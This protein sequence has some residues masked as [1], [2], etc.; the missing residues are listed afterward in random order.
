MT[1]PNPN[2]PL[3]DDIDAVLSVATVTLT[4]ENFKAIMSTYERMYQALVL[5]EGTFPVAER[6]RQAALA[7]KRSTK[8]GIISRG[9]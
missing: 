3:L 6:E 9:E 8:V 5:C 7:V 1:N 2:Q 4:V